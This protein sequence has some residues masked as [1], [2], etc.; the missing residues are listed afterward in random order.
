MYVCMYVCIIC[1][2]VYII[3]MATHTDHFMLIT[4]YK[5]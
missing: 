3:V 4:L 5:C 1:M 2:Y